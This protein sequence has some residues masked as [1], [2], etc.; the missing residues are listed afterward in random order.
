M[1]GLGTSKRE[2]SGLVS[3]YGRFQVKLFEIAEIV[4]ITN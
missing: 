1:K 4:K 2:I 3:T